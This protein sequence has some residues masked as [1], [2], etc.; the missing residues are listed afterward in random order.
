MR[1]YYMSGVQSAQIQATGVSVQVGHRIWGVAPSS[2]FAAHGRSGP[3]RFMR[4][5]VLAPDYMAGSRTIFELQV[6]RWGVRWRS[7]GEVDV[8][9]HMFD[10]IG[11]R[12]ISR[13][14][15]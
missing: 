7:R 10:E 12:W 9:H 11:W 14:A 13:R 15:L 5:I 3:A 1:P 2:W 4:V 6:W 8:G